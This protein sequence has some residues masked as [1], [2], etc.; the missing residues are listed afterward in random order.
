[1]KTIFPILML[2]SYLILAQPFAAG[3]KFATGKKGLNIYHKSWVDF[4]KNGKKDVYEDPDQAL[5]KRIEDLLQQMNLEEKT[6]QMATWYGYNRVLK[7]QLPTEDWKNKVVK[8]GIGNIDEH[9]NAVAYH[10][11]TVTQ[12]SWPPSSHAR[13]IN[14]VQRFFVEE[15][16]LGIPVDFTNEGIRG[17]CHQGATGFPAQ[18][19]IGSTWDRELVSE[20]GK[21]TATE[22]RSLGYTNIYSPILDLARDPRWG[23][24]V[25]CYSEDPCLVSNLGLE[26]VKG[27]QA[28][29]VVSTGKHFA[30]YSSPKGGRDGEARTDPQVTDRAMHEI[31]LEPF[32]T[33]T[34]EGHI[35]GFMSSYNDYNGIP[36]TGSH[37]FLTDL[38]RDTWGFKGYVVSDSWAVGGLQGRHYVAENFREAVY[39]SVEAGLNIRTNFTPPEDFILPLRELVTEGRISES[40]I[41]SR[42]RDVLRVK[43]MLGLFD[44]PYVEDPEKADTIVHNEAHVK[45][46]KRA[47]YESVVLLKN[48]VNL[49]PLNKDALGSVLITGPN[50]KAVNHSISRYG[51]SNIDVISLYDGIEN[52]VG[53]QVKLEFAQGC[54][55]YDENWPLN[56]L[57]YIAPSEK[58][59]NYIDE[60]VEKARKVDLII[61]AVGDD[62][63]T[64]GESKSRTSLNLPG[65]QEELVK[66]LYETGKPVVVVLI[67]GRPMSINWIDAYIPAII[68]A[69]F[70]GEYGGEAI[71]DVLF[72]NY[73]PGGK[74]PITFPR[75]VG[76]IPFNFPAK[77]SS[78][79]W[80]GRKEIGSTRVNSALYPFGYGLSYTTFE[81]SDLQVNPKNQVPDFD[82]ISVSFTLKNS[83][84]HAGTEIPQLYIQ[85]EYS[86]VVWY[87]KLLQGYTRVWLEPGESKQVTFYLHPKNL[88]LLNKEMKRVVEPGIFNVY[89]GA[90]SEDIR[91]SGQ[92][93]I[94]E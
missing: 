71:A 72:G 26:M 33:A 79:K 27:L 45:I 75:T 87:E 56:E 44:N 18:I 50:A 17:L 47:S 16:R 76:Q 81:Y 61:V 73:N 74:L 32:R 6:C 10:G 53:D 52:L 65:N 69:W 15:T 21:V 5:D 64:V 55:F 11:N 92:V 9:I 80:Q 66:A 31:F 34:E 39:Q 89:V 88:S 60:A 2:L 70:P 82:S 49:L 3:Q 78:Q 41:N 24:T 13:A 8:D 30:V 48:D 35:L 68:E 19:G 23:R 91:L 62:E 57:Y 42:V 4:N 58:Q 94:S 54:D 1:M 86:S 28:N 25:E 7:D 40:T 85:D 63:H 77:R 59:Q 90:S 84:Q 22:A 12:Y 14:E 37:Y 51:P 93:M 46:A 20:I 67:N 83:G 29:G 43:F 36:V 38:L